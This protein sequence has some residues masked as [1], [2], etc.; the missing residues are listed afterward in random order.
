MK[1]IGKS[2]FMRAIVT[3]LLLLGVMIV[4]PA[5]SGCDGE[6]E[7]ENTTFGN[8]VDSDWQGWTLTSGSYSWPD[9]KKVAETK[10]FSFA[11]LPRSK[12]DLLRLCALGSGSKGLEQRITSPQMAAALCYAALCNYS[13][14]ANSTKEMIV[15]L[16][17]PESE[18][19]SDWNN[20]SRRLRDYPYI[21]YALFD[22]T[23][24]LNNYTP[25]TPYTIH[26]YT[27]AQ[28]ATNGSS[29]IT[30]DRGTWTES[31]GVLYCKVFVKSSG[32][33]S[34]V[35]IM[36]KYHRASGNW[37]INGNVMVALTNIRQP[38]SSGGGY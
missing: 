21:S 10:D 6:D 28:Y 38:S 29:S 1:T 34:P 2:G 12:A 19:N 30:A 11:S 15:W 20:V 37:F 8:N 4:T 17:G 16:K 24:P 31:D 9:S 5:A 25:T 14:S 33:D 13:R 22:G 3:A 18:S 23:S 36:T 32:A 27:Q 26:P 7:I 35:P